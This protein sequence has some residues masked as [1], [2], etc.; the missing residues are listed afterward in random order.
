[1]DVK[2]AC[3]VCKEAFIKK[4]KKQKY[5]S[6]NC[7]YK[8]L[9]GSGNPFFRKKHKKEVIE[10]LRQ[11]NIGKFE[12]EKN[13][14]YGKVHDEKLKEKI[15]LANEQFRKNNK[16]LILQRQLKRL[17]LT[18][19]KIKQIFEEY[20]DTNETLASLQQ[21]YNVDKRV[22]KKYFLKFEACS[23]EELSKI[24]F[25]KKYKNATSVG[26]E[27]LYVLL[28]NLYGKE[29]VKRQHNISFY[30]YDF[31]VDDKLII[32]YD[33]FYWHNLVKNNDNIKTNLAISSGYT[34]YRVREDRNRE[35]NFLKEIQQ[36]EE[37]HEV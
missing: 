4:H 17:N 12:G 28:C 8:T 32:E 29:R 3:P 13:P 5:C 26:E 33:G 31:I 15:R 11:I 10:R 1:M 7:Y 24:S 16:D 19:E 22:L 30:Y 37:L 36:I 9:K 20:R 2:N 23:E 18:E 21:K 34:L 6:S 27:T 14:F 35:V 25:N